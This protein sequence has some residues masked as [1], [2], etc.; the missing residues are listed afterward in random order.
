MLE[1]QG[2]LPEKTQ[3]LH[4][5]K[6]LTR[7]GT[8]PGPRGAPSSCRLG[9]ASCRT[10]F[11]EHECAPSTPKHPHARAMAMFLPAAFRGAR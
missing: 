5:R 11:E 9:S 6:M 3:Q 1:L 10:L 2:P 8:M 4:M 7:T